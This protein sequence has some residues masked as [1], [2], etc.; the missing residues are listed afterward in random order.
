VFEIGLFAVTSTKQLFFVPLHSGVK[1]ATVFTVD[2]CMMGRSFRK[3]TR[4]AT[5]GVDE[6]VA[7]EAKQIVKKY[8]CKSCKGICDRT[9]RPHLYLRGWT[10]GKAVTAKGNEYPR[11]FANLIAKL[12]CSRCS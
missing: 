4:L 3:R 8:Q 9:K 7:A 12:G 11:K 6:E 5:W 10:R 1:V 2:Y